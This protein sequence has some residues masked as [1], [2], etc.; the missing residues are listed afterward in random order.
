MSK[1]FEVQACLHVGNRNKCTKE[2]AVR[3]LIRW[4]ML[5]GEHTFFLYVGV[6]KDEQM[7][8]DTCK[9]VG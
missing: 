2:L 6:V 3:L 5:T 4:S 7:C 8:K 9:V 1:C